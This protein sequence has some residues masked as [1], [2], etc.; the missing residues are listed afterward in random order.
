[1]TGPNSFTMLRPTMP[2]MLPSS[3][4]C[5][6]RDPVCSARTPPM[7]MAMTMTVKRKVIRF[8]RCDDERSMC[9]K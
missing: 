6:S 4:N 1:M 9:R 5:A 2:P 3:P 8:H 7:K